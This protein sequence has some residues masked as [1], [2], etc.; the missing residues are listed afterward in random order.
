MDSE[1]K[2]QLGGIEAG[3]EARK[4]MA[5][6]SGQFKCNGCGG[7]SNREIMKEREEEAAKADGPGV[8]D[9]VPEE[10]KL[11]YRD[12][13]GKG[14]EKEKE[15]QTSSNSKD[16]SATIQEVE[17]IS[18]LPSASQIATE[19]STTSETTVPQTVIPTPQAPIL[20]AQPGQAAQTQP[21]RRQQA[22][23]TQ[24]SSSWLDMAIIGIAVALGIMVLRKVLSLTD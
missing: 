3:A 8:E 1:A 9:K 22:T 15:N 5:A 11:G 2:G 23:V 24:E 7:R 4:R 17:G 14:K 10:L 18:K 6:E 12:E 21:S 16:S 20:P 19:P 13:L